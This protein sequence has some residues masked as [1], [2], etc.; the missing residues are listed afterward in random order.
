MFPLAA[1]PASSSSSG[2]R[3]FGGTSLEPADRFYDPRADPFHARARHI[4]STVDLIDACQISLPS[5]E[6]VSPKFQFLYLHLCAHPGPATRAEERRM[7]HLAA[8]GSLRPSAPNAGAW[9]KHALVPRNTPPLARFAARTYPRNS[10]RLVR[11]FRAD[12]SRRGARAKY[13]PWLA[14]ARAA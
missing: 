5:S 6:S 12:M 11:W 10:P 9:M 3:T 13:K 14:R 8:A 2:P 4:R 1:Y 7:K